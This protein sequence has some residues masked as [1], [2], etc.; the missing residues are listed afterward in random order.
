MFNKCESVPITEKKA[1]PRIFL[2]S[3]KTIELFPASNEDLKLFGVQGYSFVSFSM[4]EI[5]SK[6][7]KLAS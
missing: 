7:P 3:F 4:V 2:L 1:Y 6:S 5:W